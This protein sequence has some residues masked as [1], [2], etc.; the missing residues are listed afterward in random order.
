MGR[1]VVVGCVANLRA[2]EAGRQGR[3]V[4]QE[5]RQAGRDKE[6]EGGG[7]KGGGVFRC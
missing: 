2:G 4:R 5:G 6:R 1:K 7:T 3:Q